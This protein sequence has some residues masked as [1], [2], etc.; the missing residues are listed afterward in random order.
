M[1]EVTSVV[2][3]WERSITRAC[4]TFLNFT[5]GTTERINRLEAENI[6]NFMEVIRHRTSEEIRKAYEKGYRD[7]K[8]G[9]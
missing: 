7:A 4:R 6:Q 1:N 8:Q 2:E 3:E 5:F 9:K